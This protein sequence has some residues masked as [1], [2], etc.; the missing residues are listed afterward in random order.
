VITIE[1]ADPQIAYVPQYNPAV[2]YGTPYY[3]PGYTAR[4]FALDSLL[5]FGA[6]WQW[7]LWLAA[8]ADV[9]GGDGDPGTAIGKA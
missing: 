3:T 9:A 1:P 2:V 6:G 5:G 8:V 7:E 4:D